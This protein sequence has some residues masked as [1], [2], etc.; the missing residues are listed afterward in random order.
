MDPKVIGISGSPVKNS[1]TDRL[2][3]TILESS[4]L[5]HEFVKLSQKKYSHALPALVVQRIIFAK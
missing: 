5:P 1:N 3:K 2:V 4:G